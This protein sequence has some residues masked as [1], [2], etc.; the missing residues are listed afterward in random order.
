[1]SDL[2][3]VLPDGFP[4]HHFSHLLPSLDR[5]RVTTTDILTLDAV[6]LAKRAQV[7]VAELRKLQQAIVSALHAELGVA[8]S[9]EAADA[10]NNAVADGWHAAEWRTIS[11]LDDSLDAELGGGIPAGYLTEITGESGAGKTQFLLTLLLSAQLPAPHGFSKSALYISTEAPLATTRL[12]QLLN[13]H[14]RLTSLPPSSKPS[15]SRILSIQTPDL[16]SQDHILRYQLPV[17]IQRHNV[18]LVV[19]DSVA[20]NYR[21]EFERGGGSGGGGGGGGSEKDGGSRRAVGEAMAHRTAQL[22]QLGALLRSVARTH[23]VAVVV[24]NQ[25]SDR[26]SAPPPPPPSSTTTSRHPSYNSTFSQ[27][28]RVPTPGP[29]PPSQQGGGGVAAAAGATSTPP[30]PPPPPPGTATTAPLTLSRDPLTL[31]HQ[32]RWFTGWGDVRASSSASENLKTPALGLVWA[33][34]IAA[35]IALLKA[36]V[37]NAPNPWIGLAADGRLD[38]RGEGDGDGDEGGGTEIKRWR[39]WMKV[40]FAPWA[41]PSVGR[42]VE[43]VIRGRGVVAA[44]A[45]AGAEGKAKEREK[46]GVEDEIEEKK[47]VE[48]EVEEEGREEQQVKEGEDGPAGEQQPR[49]GSEPLADRN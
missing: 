29:G 3:H 30:P 1:M 2:H 46:K 41:P 4:A 27:T 32:Q 14:P 10:G 9:V 17:A 6:D 18:G 43:Y 39:R 26:F 34:Q 8:D 21:A 13:Q 25:V 28:S 12:A 23:G 42:G 45:G 37:Y 31:D 36:P 7:P 20:A 24:A 16:E 15:L 35:R 40:V 5:H 11:T 47:G 38:W 22:V 48:D 44:S 49:A 33:N 19:L